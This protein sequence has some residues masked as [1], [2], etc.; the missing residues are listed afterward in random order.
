[1]VVC[2]D[3]KAARRHA[4]A[5]IRT[6]LASEAGQGPINLNRHIEVT[7]LEGAP[8]LYVSFCEAII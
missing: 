1:M 2:G 6:I 4:I 5:A 8:V 3:L 7:D